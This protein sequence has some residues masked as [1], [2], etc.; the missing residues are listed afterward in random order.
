MSSQNSRTTKE[1]NRK[2]LHPDLP[3]PVSTRVDV[4]FSNPGQSTFDRKAE[5]M[6][7]FLKRNPVPKEFLN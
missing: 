2:G 4:E 3:V 7:A 1:K 5:E 6:K